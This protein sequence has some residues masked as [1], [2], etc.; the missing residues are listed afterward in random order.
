MS[1]LNRARIS[2]NRR[3]RSVIFG[4]VVCPTL[5]AILWFGIF[6]GEIW[7]LIAVP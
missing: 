1:I 7:I 6:G 5:Y 2:K 3:L 4:C